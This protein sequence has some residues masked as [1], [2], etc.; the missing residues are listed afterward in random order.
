MTIQRMHSSTARCWRLAALLA[1]LG[2]TSASAVDER[3]I[4]E[5]RL[6]RLTCY[7]GYLKLEAP[8][9]LEGVRAAI[10]QATAQKDQ[11]AL[12]F[13]EQRLTEVIGEDA[14]AALQVI[15]WAH[16]AQEPEMS[17]YLRSVRETEAVRSPAVVDRLTTLAESHQDPGHQTSALIALETQHRFE[18]AMLERLTTLA[19]KDTLVTGVA[20]HTVRT[21]GRVMDNDFQR[22][23]RFD[24]YM[25][26]LLE[27]A[28]DS[29]EPDVRG[30]AIE[31]GTYPNARIDGQS[32]QHLAKLQLEDP[33]PSVREMAALVMSSGRD[34]QAVLD[35]F[36]KSFPQEKNECVRWAIVRYAVRAAGARALP[37]L[38]DFAQQDARFR[39]DHT[40]FKALYDAGLVDF[41]RVF[42]GKANHHRC[43]DPE[44]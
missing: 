24:P 12:L 21:I 18:P 38:K 17:L 40:E 15:E 26:K 39:R 14:Q 22:T 9:G 29:T 8:H 44:E 13:L 23:G 2:T 19:K 31:M 7:S 34:T 42:P 10:R 25:G 3:P 11:A 41:D 37:L 30:L 27:V 33:D 32:L 16:T 6:P 43:E 20:M 28:L 35:A 4:A 5:P 36:R 1:T